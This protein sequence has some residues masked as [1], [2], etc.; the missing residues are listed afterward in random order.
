VIDVPSTNGLLE[1]FT[2]TGLVALSICSGLPQVAT[3]KVNVA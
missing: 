1:P 2:L 3:I